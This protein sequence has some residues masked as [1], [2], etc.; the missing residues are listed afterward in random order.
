[1]IKRK[2]SILINCP[3]EV[4][5]NY[6]TTPANW[7]EHLPTS[8]EIKPEINRPLMKGE[9]L[10]EFVKIKGL[11]GWVNWDCMENDG[12]SLFTV[13]G[14]SESFGGSRT[15]ISYTF[16]EDNGKTVFNRIVEVSQNKLMMKM[17]EPMIKIYV[18][19]EADFIMAKV[20][21]VLER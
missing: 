12:Q 7:L 17:M 20:K 4:V 1:M 18:K 11:S 6:L 5:F 9:K 15:S 19:K 16:S 2:D 8:F 13:Q 14:S 21:E 3:R 10:S